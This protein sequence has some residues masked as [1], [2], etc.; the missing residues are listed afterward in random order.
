MS[1]FDV[2]QPAVQFSMQAVDVHA[3]LLGGQGA[4]TPPKLQIGRE[5]NFHPM[6]CKLCHNNWDAFA[7]LTDLSA[8]PR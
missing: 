8:K 5:L 1:Y 2:N 6:S 7:I 4:P 3:A